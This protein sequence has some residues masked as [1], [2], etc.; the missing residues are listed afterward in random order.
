MRRD[1]WQVVLAS[2]FGAFV[3]AFVALEISSRFEYGR[4][5]WGLGVIVGGLAGYVS[6]DFA[7]LREGVAL[8][9]RRTIT[10]RPDWPFWGV[11]GM[12][13]LIFSVASSNIAFLVGL[14]SLNLT[15]SLVVFKV[16]EVICFIFTIVGF[17]EGLVSDSNLYHG[18]RVE[19]RKGHLREI[20]D[21]GKVILLVNPIAVWFYWLPWG[22]WYLARRAPAAAVMASAQTGLVLSR[23]AS[24]FV[25]FVSTSFHY[26][27]SHKRT[28]CLA[29]A[30]IGAA[31]GH[32]A[33]SAVVGAVFGAVLGVVEYQLVAIRWLKVVPNGNRA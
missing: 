2:A 13:F 1:F 28:I 29:A 24:A 25:R 31:V 8:A 17:A 16:F 18:D 4:Y 5:F 32:E 3:G 33:G 20:R 10:W 26:V 11:I 15:N 27:H 30:A 21:M 9:Y 23:A 14:L 12:M 7:E 6:V 22:V 19:R